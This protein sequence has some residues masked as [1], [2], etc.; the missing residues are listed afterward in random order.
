M[1]TFASPKLRAYAIVAALGLLAALALGRPEP[2]ALAAPFVLV[3]A[4]GLALSRAPD[5]GLALRLDRDRALEGEVI[6]L[7]LAMLPQTPV[8]A[9]DLLLHLPAGLE[10]AADGTA[11]S[12]RLAAGE[13]RSV[14]WAVRC[15]RWG[16]YVLGDLVLRA[17]DPFGLFQFQAR[18]NGQLPL[19]VY[20]RVETLRALIRPAETQ[21]YTGNEVSRQVGDGIEF[22][23]I[24][25][26]VP[27]DRVRDVNWRV[28]A[29]RGA[30]YVNRQHPERNADVVLFLDTF[31]AQTRAGDA[32]IA[33][34]V[35]AAAALTAHYL[36]RRD[37]VGLVSFGG[38]LRWVTPAMGVV[39]QYRIVES[40]LD[41]HIV[42]SYA[43]R[44]VDTIP[45]RLLPPKALVVAI[46]PLLDR[47]TVDA[48][49]DLRARGFDLAIVEVSPLPFVAPERSEA[50]RLAYRLWKLRREA[51]RT[52]YQ[53]LGVSVVVWDQEAP[54][55][56]V[57][58]EVQA[59]RRYAR[60]VRA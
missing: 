59:F 8:E 5:L 23:G 47:R 31:M 57:V 54:L 3:L 34:V 37:R 58:E 36:A 45:A 21:V 25:E 29:R 52:Q 24:R 46:T 7:Q 15:Q 14:S 9:L 40:L 60:H 32:I 6:T 41:T 43:W 38:I 2:L 17:R 20:P 13:D 19:R 4:V 44:G 1:T 49:L 39:Q 28:S 30:L 51:L 18:L 12:I 53:R 26:F 33:L 16:G 35:R 48:L 10:P 56:R 22:A 42:L 50:G 55:G 27:G 11:M